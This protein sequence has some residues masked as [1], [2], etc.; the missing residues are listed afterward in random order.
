MGDVLLLPFP[1]PFALPFPFVV[2]GGV[3]VVPTSVHPS[4]AAARAVQSTA[5]S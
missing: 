3:G 2:T 4:F 5:W 1:F